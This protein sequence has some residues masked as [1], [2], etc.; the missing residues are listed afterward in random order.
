MLDEHSNMK[1]LFAT[2]SIIKF[3]NHWDV[4][5]IFFLNFI[6]LIVII[7]FTLSLFQR[8]KL[9]N[10]RSALWNLYPHKL[11]SRQSLQFGGESQIDSSSCITYI[12]NGIFAAK[13]KTDW[14]DSRVLQIVNRLAKGSDVKANWEACLLRFTKLDI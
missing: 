12:W 7:V 6:N 1:F 9:A 10:I 14:T 2:F 3:E 4:I 11:L 5:N 8:A 13:S